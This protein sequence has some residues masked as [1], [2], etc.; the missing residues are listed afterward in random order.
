M[1]TAMIRLFAVAMFA[2]ALLLFWVQPLLTKSILPLLGGTPAVWNAALVF[3]QGGA[4]HRLPLRTPV[5]TMAGGSAATDPASRAARRG[6]ARPPDRSSGGLAASHGGDSGP[7]VAG[8]PDGLPGGAIHRALGH[9]TAS[10]ALVRDDGSPRRRRPLLVATLIFASA[11]VARRRPGRETASTLA[12]TA[13]PDWRSKARWILLAFAPS[14]LLIG[15]T[16]HITT[17]IAAGPLLWVLPLALYLLTFVIVFSRRPVLRHSWM[18][19]TV[20]Y[21]A[22]V[23]AILLSLAASAHLPL[24]FLFLHLGAFFALAMVCHGEL[25][26]TRPAAAHLTGFYLWIALG[27]SWAG[28]SPRSSRQSSLTR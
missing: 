5:L 8:G 23:M 3:F 7:V 21:V 11:W 6:R 18:I 12:Q 1:A 28:R 17:N 4:A 22:I 10:P 19:R 25:A 15:V 16:T 9:R 27:G 13:P 20:P 24:P 2:S 14:S 26:H